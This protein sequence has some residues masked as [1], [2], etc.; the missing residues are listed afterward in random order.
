M[1][2]L[3]NHSEYKDLAE[4]PDK[5]FACNVSN[6]RT[7]EVM[8]KLFD[9]VLKMFPHAEYL[10]VGNDEVAN[11]GRYPFR[12][13]NIST[14]P[15]QLFLKN[16]K[17]CEDYAQ[18]RKIKLMV[19]QDKPVHGDMSKSI[20][21]RAWQDFARDTAVAVWDYDVRAD[22]PD[23][24]LFKKQGHATFGATG[25]HRTSDP[26]PAALNNLSSYARYAR[27]NGLDGMIQT[28]WTG[29]E[30]CSDVLFAYSPQY[31]LHAEAACVFWNVSYIPRLYPDSKGSCNRERF[32]AAVSRIAPETYIFN[33]KERISYID[34]SKFLNVFLSA[35]GL[36][37]D[38]WQ[39]NEI[40][41]TAGGMFNIAGCSGKP[42]AALVKK[43]NPL[44]VS[45]SRPPKAVSLL[46]ASSGSQ[47][48]MSKV[49]MITVK[50]RD[51][52]KV[53]PILIGKEILPSAAEIQPRATV[54]SMLSPSGF[55]N[56]SQY[57]MR[58]PADASS[59]T[60]TAESPIII[61]AVSVVE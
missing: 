5:P 24:E 20:F 52:V 54:H 36:K 21:S 47:A 40:Y 44:A 56:L 27:T 57:T 14:P 41:G 25:M 22:F 45:F 59:M 7:F 37:T 18:R 50:S 13:E 23:A 53:T 33:G 32:D 35:P 43:D 29:L 9:D 49:G 4:D 15:W 16:Q 31:W 26:L 28:T 10:H 34:I 46:W 8:T 39:P 61:A 60:V 11:R 19:W 58:L 30:N 3:L 2:W 48:L 17:F 1:E 51:G 12:P 38:D 6:P 55:S 42:L